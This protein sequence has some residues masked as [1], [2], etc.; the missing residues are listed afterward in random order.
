MCVHGLTNWL[1][2]CWVLGQLLETQ[3]CSFLTASSA[4][5]GWQGWPAAGYLVMLPLFNLPLGALQLL[6]QCVLGENSCEPRCP[7]SPPPRLLYSGSG[8][9]LPAR[10]AFRSALPAL[11]LLARPP[12]PQPRLLLFSLTPLHSPP[13]SPPR[14]APQPRPLPT[15]LSH[16]NHSRS[17]G[18]THTFTHTAPFRQ[19]RPSGQHCPSRPATHSTFSSRAA[20]RSLRWSCR[21][22]FDSLSSRSTVSDSRLPWSS[23]IFSRWRTCITRPPC[24]KPPQGHLTAIPGSHSFLLWFQPS[25]LSPSYPPGAPVCS[26]PDHLLPPLCG[27]VSVPSQVLP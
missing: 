13:H 4:L 17:P 8:L 12:H 16:P 3:A 19:R 14:P 23:F 6:D 2:Q 25:H 5:P 21:R 24:T 11:P 20:M 27:S 15:K 1:A 10:S 7:P 26:F 22:S 18:S 9:P